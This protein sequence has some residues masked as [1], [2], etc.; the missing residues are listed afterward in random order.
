MEQGSFVFLSHKS[1]E[2]ELARRMKVAIEKRFPVWWDKDLQS[3]RRWAAELDDR[4][5]EAGVVVVVLTKMSMN[6]KWV[7]IEAHFA[8]ITDRLVPVLAEDLDASE[9]LAPYVDWQ[10]I[11]LPGWGDSDIEEHPKW[12]QVLRSIEVKMLAS[13]PNGPK[14]WVLK[15]YASAQSTSGR[16]GVPAFITSPVTYHD[17]RYLGLVQEQRKLM[18]LDGMTVIPRPPFPLTL[19]GGMGVVTLSGDNLM[20]KLR[21]LDRE[22]QVPWQYLESIQNTNGPQT[23]WEIGFSKT[24]NVTWGRNYF[25]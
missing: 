15:E 10:Y 9:V 23:E 19:Q 17:P 25:G 7:L 18:H 11:A 3:G 20:V 4:L 14:G 24:L 1:E 13:T 12:P 22:A 16:T 8:H 21:G 6:S 5:R 2:H